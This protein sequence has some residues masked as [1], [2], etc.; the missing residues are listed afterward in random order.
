MKKPK[1]VK[2]KPPKPPKRPQGFHM[3]GEEERKRIAQSMARTFESRRVTQRANRIRDLKAGAERGDMLTA[4]NAAEQKALDSGGVAGLAVHRGRKPKHFQQSMIDARDRPNKYGKKK[5]KKMAKPTQQTLPFAQNASTEIFGRTIRE[6]L[7][8]FI[9]S[10]LVRHYKAARAE[11]HSSKSAARYAKRV[12]VPISKKA[13]PD[14]ARTDRVSRFIQP[15]DSR[16]LQK[17]IRKGFNKAY[18]DSGRE[19]AR[20]IAKER[21]LRGEGTT[22]KKKATARRKAR[23]AKQAKAKPLKVKPSTQGNNKPLTPIE[24]ERARARLARARGVNAEGKV[25]STLVQSILDILTDQK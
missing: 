12:G 9:E 5:P 18:G 20:K 15:D 22:D 23:K 11:G 4:R 17:E 24:K 7:R 6:G 10:D 13:D 2:P 8:I 14:D 19:S 1:K 21:D 16:G 3:G 25:E